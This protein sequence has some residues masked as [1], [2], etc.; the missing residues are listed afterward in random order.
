LQIKISRRDFLS[1]SL[2]IGVYETIGNK[3]SARAA[4]SSELDSTDKSLVRARIKGLLLGSMIGDAVGGPI[5]FQ[6]TEDVADVVPNCRRWRDDRQ[7]TSDDLLLF[8]ASLRLH[9][10]EK[11]RPEPEPYGQWRSAAAPGTITDD[12]RHKM[13]LIDALQEAIKK[14]RLPITERDLATAYLQFAGSE[15]IAKRPEYHDLCEESFQEFWK[16][17]RWVL[18]SR[19]LKVAAPPERI[20]GGVPTCCGQMAMLPL[21]AI[22]SGRPVE[23]Y[24]ATFALS[25]FDVG[26]AKDINS[27]VVAGLSVA[28]RQAAPTDQRSRKLAWQ[29]ITDVMRATDPYQYAKVPYV[30]RPTT[31]WLDFAHQAVL[32]AERKPKLLYEILEKEGQVKYFWEAHF[33]LALVFSVIEFCA[34][35]PLAAMLLTLDFGHDTDSAAQL[36]GAFIGALYGPGLFPEHLQHPVVKRLA[37]DY[38]ESVAEWTD[39]LY[40][41]SD[42]EKYPEVVALE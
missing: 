10:Y 31:Y 14:Q 29:A 11:Y 16:S 39:L 22:Y 35:D 28:L 41:L 19:D 34:Y 38:D 8:G 40:S 1:T 23:A 6:K 9:S 36:L 4:G 18:G 42:Q 17:A 26:A 5:E 15:A 32:Q 30:P 33:V 2:S 13:I 20:W 12:T 24:R 7:L 21:A 3:Q 27:A 25:F 37:E